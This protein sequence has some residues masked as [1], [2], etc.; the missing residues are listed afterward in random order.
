MAARP[1]SDH[2]TTLNKLEESVSSLRQEWRKANLPK[3]HLLKGELD[4]CID[5]I[6]NMAADV[7]TAKN[8]ST[9][10]PLL[11]SSTERSCCSSS[12]KTDL[13]TINVPTFSGEIMEWATFWASFKSTVDS[14][15]DLSNTKKLIYLRQAIKDPNTQMMLHSPSETDDM[16]LEVVEELQFRFNRTKEVHRQLVKS[17]LHLQHPKHTREDLRLLGDTVKRMVDSIKTNGHYDAD[18]ILT[19]LVYLTLP[20]RLQTLWD[21]HTRKEKRVL[22]LPQMLAFLRE[23]AV[24]LPAGQPTTER[25]ADAS[26]R[27]APRRQDKK[28]EQQHKQKSHVHVVSSTSTYKWECALCK[29][30]KHPLHVCPKWLGYSVAQRLSH[31]RAKNLCSNCLAVGHL[32]TACKSTYRCRDCGQAHHTT[33]HQESSPPTQV[34]STMVQSQ[35][36][37]DALLMTA[38]VLLKGP[39]G[40]ELKARAFL[41]PGAAISLISS[42]VTQ[43]LDL[44][45]E[46]NRVRFSAVQGTPCNI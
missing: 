31:V 24:T 13:P 38:E 34:L 44:P 17:L 12:S 11:T 18:A 2:S 20:S 7:A 25:S 41:D 4:A 22:P 45:L 26:E 29:P 42:R 6:P 37:P 46:P 1:E 19:S 35:Q 15:K 3:D 33:I 8:K 39:G 16:Y 10:S 30:D 43:I 28:Q 32:T 5:S 40:H 27:K 23:H 14:R 21:Q 36:V 9:H